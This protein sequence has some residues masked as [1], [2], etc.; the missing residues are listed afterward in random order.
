MPSNEAKFAIGLFALILIS[1]LLTPFWHTL[2]FYKESSIA[3]SI[4]R[5]DA[6]AQEKVCF[7]LLLKP[8]AFLAEKTTPI[9]AKID[10]KVVFTGEQN[11]YQKP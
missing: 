9:I 4:E 1:V 7:D 11:T 2:I 6:I 3:V 10:D 8:T 5:F